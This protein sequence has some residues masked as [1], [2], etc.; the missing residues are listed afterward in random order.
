MAA[1]GVA[2]VTDNF[3]A[4]TSNNTPYIFVYPWSSGFGTKASDPATKPGGISHSPTFNSAASVIAMGNDSSMP[5]VAYPWSGGAFGTKVSDPASPP[6]ADA[7]YGYNS[8]TFSPTGA[9]IAIAGESGS[10]FVYV[11]PY[12]SGFGSKYADPATTPNYGNGVTFSPSGSTIVTV[13]ALTPYIDAWPFTHGSGFG[14]KYSNPASLPL[15]GGQPAFN[16]AG[17]VVVSSIASSS[18]AAYAWSSG[19]GSRY[20]DPGSP[21]AGTQNWVTFSPSGGHVAY[22]TTTSPYSMFTRGVADLEQRCLTL[23]HYPLAQ[24]RRWLSVYPVV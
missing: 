15:A 12:S 5:I 1:Y 21:P 17:T 11:Y 22:A 9:D 16:P 3:I 20:S 6:P 4:V 14:S 8:C 19:F 18:T 24:H 13:D 7:G 23:L 2:S 10:P